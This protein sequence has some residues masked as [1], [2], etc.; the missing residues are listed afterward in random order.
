MN[1]AVVMETTA[2]LSKVDL[3]DLD[4]QG[5]IGLRMSELQIDNMACCG[6][7][8]FFVPKSADLPS[9]TQACHRG[10]TTTLFSKWAARCP[11]FNLLAPLSDQPQ[12]DERGTGDRRYATLPYARE[13]R[14]GKDRRRP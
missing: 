7:C 8:Q 5:V 4:A 3:H 2:S 12:E 9:A 11:D 13:R 1:P 14:S 10:Y 6:D